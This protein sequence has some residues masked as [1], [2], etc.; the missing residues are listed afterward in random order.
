M[1][2]GPG[3]PAVKQTAHAL[4][5]KARLLAAT[6]ERAVPVATH[7]VTK[8]TQRRQIRRHT[9]ITIVSLDHRPQPLANFGHRI[10]HSFTVG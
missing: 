2:L 9:V 5:R 10:V 3:Q 4:P 6:P 1:Q 8:R 7:M